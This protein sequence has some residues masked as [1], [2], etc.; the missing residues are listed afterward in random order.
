VIFDSAPWKA[1]LAK[2]ADELEEAAKRRASG[3]RS[4]LIERH[5][6][7][8]AYAI[9]KLAEANKLTTGILDEPVKVKLFPPTR[10]GFSA[11]RLMDIEAFFAT[12]APIERQLPRRRL[13][14]I[15]VHSLVFIEVVGARQQ[16]QGFLVTSDHSVKEGLYEV[17][18]AEFIKLMRLVAQDFP[19]V[20]TLTATEDGSMLVWTGRTPPEPD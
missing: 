6:F 18:L 2:D 9:R 17:E 12:E 15:L 7:L 16:C 19:T 13:L 1:Q 11:P 4:V 14:N 10:R 5:V 20:L 3:K 8:G